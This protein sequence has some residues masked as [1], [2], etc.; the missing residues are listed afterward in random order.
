MTEENNQ[1]ILT[2]KEAAKMLEKHPE[3]I[4]RW[5]KAKKL[6]ARKVAGEYG[7]YLVSRQDLLEYMV[8]GLV[9]RRN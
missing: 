2:V 5:I 6:P 9:K 4:R 3:T 8:K 1:D 7:L